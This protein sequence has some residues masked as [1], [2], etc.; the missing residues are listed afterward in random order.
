MQLATLAKASSAVAATRSRK[1]KIALLAEVLGQLEASEMRIASAYLAGELPQGKIGLGAALVQAAAGSPALEPSL[2]LRSVSDAFDR[3]AAARGPGSAGAKREQLT[4]LFARATAQEQTL[5]ANLILGNL[6]QGALEAI[7]IEAIAAA[8]ALEPSIVRRACML[9]GGLP[10]IAQAALTGGAAALAAFDLQLMR[11]VQPMLAQPADDLAD[12]MQ[13]LGSAALEYKLDGARIQ[14]HRAGGEVR[15]FSRALND[16]TAAVPE[17]VAAVLAL[18]EDQLILDGEVL[19][20]RDNG[21]PQPF[22]V[23][24]RRFGR[25]GGDALRAALPLAPHFFDCLYA[26]GASL[27]DQSMEARMA[28]LEDLVPPSMRVPRIV[29]A[30]AERGQTFWRQALAAGHEGLMV[31]SLTAP[32]EAGARGSNWLKIKPAHTLD[33]V[34]LAAEWGSGR[35]RGWLSNLHLGARD[36]DSDSFVMLGK[37]FKGMTDAL[38]QWQT[39]R[40][41]ELEVGREPNVVHVEPSLVVEV[42][43]SD[44]QTSPRYVGGL[45]LRFARVKHYRPDKRPVDADTIE[46]VRELQRRSLA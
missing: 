25:R 12:A 28:F 39:E 43:F 2:D 22:Q 40:L 9:A 30:D 29:T 20:L 1:Q 6:R 4:A 44:V 32:Y 38:L 11:P 26:N 34:V 15:V 35:R 41:L 18:P 23:T 10:Q 19:A 45:A 46:T 16:V 31:K 8:G 13:Q 21:R 33:L 3:I 17:V 14:V 42:A 24:M 7:V 36:A 37:T 27:L 5:L